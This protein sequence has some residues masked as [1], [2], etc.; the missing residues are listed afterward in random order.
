MAFEANLQ[1]L[2]LFVA[3]SDY[4]ASTDQFTLVALTTDNP[5]QLANNT[6]QGT[7]SF[8]LQ[9]TPTS[10]QSAQIAVHGVTKVVV[11][12]THAAV[13]PGVRLFCG[14][15]AVAHTATSSG[16]IPIGIAL[17]TLAADTSGIVSMLV[18][19]AFYTATTG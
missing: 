19:N 16:Y 10:G 14:S 5:A 13:Y 8:V 6:S 9:N 2:G 4:S 3:S 12:S 15:A 18:T 17:E 11:G 7:R 1:T